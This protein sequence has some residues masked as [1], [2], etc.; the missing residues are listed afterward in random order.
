MEDNIGLDVT[1]FCSFTELMEDRHGKKAVDK[2][3]EKIMKLLG[4]IDR[5]YA[6]LP[7]VEVIK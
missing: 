6:E 1:L 4:E 3:I 5:L 2:N 7:N